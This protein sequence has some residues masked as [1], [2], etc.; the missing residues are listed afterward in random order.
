[1]SHLLARFGLL[2]QLLHWRTL[3]A[4]EVAAQQ[5]HTAQGYSTNLLGF[6]EMKVD[7]G[8]ATRLGRVVTT[9]LRIVG[10]PRSEVG[11]ERPQ[12]QYI[13]SRSRAN[14]SALV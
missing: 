5:R 10:V 6:M 9:M 3:P 8:S 11:L 1:M 12:S 2:Q 7:R 4:N 14:S 13:D